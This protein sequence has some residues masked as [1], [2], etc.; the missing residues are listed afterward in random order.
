MPRLSYQSENMFVLLEKGVLLAPRFDS[1]EDDI[2]KPPGNDGG[3]KYEEHMKK[4][5]QCRTLK[6]AQLLIKSFYRTFHMS[7]HLSHGTLPK[8]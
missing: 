6:G 3:Y 4:R 8:N 2:K 1:P 7:Y 5:N